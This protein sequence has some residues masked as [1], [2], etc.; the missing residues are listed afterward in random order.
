MRKTVARV[1]L[2]YYWPG[3]LDDVE[4][5]CR[6]CVVCQRRKNPRSKNIAP[7]QSI[8]TGVAP[9]EQVALDILKLP[10]TSRGNQYVLLIEDYFS[11]WVEAFPLE[12]T[13]APSVAQC[14]M[15]G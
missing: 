4:E 2:R 12:R 8:G 7:L 9:F 15:N 5:W 6:T 3:Y 13:V 11:K 1:K 14:V 10:L